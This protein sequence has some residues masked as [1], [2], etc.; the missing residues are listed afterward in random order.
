MSAWLF[1]DLDGLMD[2]TRAYPE[3]ERSIGQGD[4]ELSWVDQGSRGWRDGNDLIVGN[5]W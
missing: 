2:G 4:T 5:S 1:V 3:K